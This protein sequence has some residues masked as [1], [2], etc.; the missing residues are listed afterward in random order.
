MATVATSMARIFI[1]YRRDDDAYAGRIY[2]RLSSA[3]GKEQVFMD[4]QGISAGEDFENTIQNSITNSDTV[5]VLIGKNWLKTKTAL[6]RIRLS[7]PNDYVRLEIRTALRLSLRIIPVLLSDTKMP[8]STQLP[9]DIDQLAK[10]QAVT[11]STSTFELDIVTLV[12]AIRNKSI[13]RDEIRLDLAVPAPAAW[14][15]KLTVWMEASN[16]LLFLLCVVSVVVGFSSNQSFSNQVSTIAGLLLCSAGMVFGH[17]S[18]VY[19]VPKGALFGWLFLPVFTGLYLSNWF[20]VKFILLGGE[21]FTNGLFAYGTLGVGAWLT[22]AT[23]KRFHARDLATRSQGYESLWSSEVCGFPARIKIM[24]IAY[25]IAVFWLLVPLEGTLRIPPLFWVILLVLGAI[26]GNAG[27]WTRNTSALILGWIITPML[28]MC[29]ALHWVIPNILTDEDNYTLISFGSIFGILLFTFYVASRLAGTPERSRDLSRVVTLTGLLSMG[30]VLYLL[31]HC[32]YLYTSSLILLNWMRLLTLISV[33]L[34][35]YTADLSRHSGKLNVRTSLLCFGVLLYGCTG[36]LTGIVIDPS[37]AALAGADVHVGSYRAITD[38]EGRFA[39][40]LMPPATYTWSANQ[41]HFK[42]AW[43][44]NE[45]V[46]SL[47]PSETTVVLQVGSGK[48]EIRFGSNSRPV[49][50]FCNLGIIA[51]IVITS[52]NRS[53]AISRISAR[54][55]DARSSR[56]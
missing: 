24:L 56:V 51:T 46:P 12:E 26:I 14:N 52:R 43:I 41:N 20:G 27:L 1:C 29:F 37:G 44:E 49:F 8:D 11:I 53:K 9:A 36:S 17:Y 34:A 30:W 13:A 2:D 18:Y 38:S 25:A 22:V 23:M 10:H 31:A 16:V 40:P 19:G 4:T 54:T 35:L 28:A 3:F 6:G 7:D 33:P 50:L 15:S 42:Q 5:L 21:D 32:V 47:V 39:F 55:E 48:N 45:F